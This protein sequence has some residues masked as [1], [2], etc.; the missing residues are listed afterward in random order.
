MTVNDNVNDV[1]RF[2]YNS[3]IIN[4]HIGR[5]SLAKTRLGQEV[6]YTPC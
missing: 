2:T 4:E 6:H 5:V 1:V 3:Q